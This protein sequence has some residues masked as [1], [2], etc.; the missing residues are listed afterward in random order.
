[1]TI[2]N[3]TIYYLIA[4]IGAV[5]LSVIFTIIVKKIATHF[6]IVDCPSTAPE[7]KI[8]KKPIPLLGGV[9]V[10]LSFSIIL[11]L[12][13]FFSDIFINSTKVL[14]KHLWGILLAGFIIM[15]GGVLDD[16]FN[17]SWKKQLFFSITAVIVVIVSGIGMEFI[18]NPFGGIINFSKIEINLFSFN[19]IPYKIFIIADLF[20]FVWLLGMMQTTK[21]L[22]GLDGL[23]T[24]VSV[25]ASLVLFFLSLNI[26]EPQ[27]ALLAIIFAG[28]SF[29]FLFF[30][31]NPAKIFLGEGGALFAGFIIAILG[32]LS[33]GKVATVFLVMGIPIL[34][35]VW[36]IVRRIFWEKKSPFSNADKKHFHHRLLEIGL[37]QTKAVLL[38]YFF[39][40]VFGVLAL[41]SRSMGKFWAIIILSLMMLVLG[42]LVECVS[43]KQ[44]KP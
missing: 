29:G 41:C 20:T 11:I 24:G 7:R 31:F 1:M 15:L 38:L 39:S 10:F 37:S 32:V 22:D 8:H 4:F 21:L 5:F 40:F 19:N 43:K 17:L 2:S 27:V 28:S 42:V 18:S 25:I 26:R 35:V 12:S 44:Q 34:D 13:Y 3:P 16:K 30:N 23:V 6:N 9:A 14:D 36:V 33:V